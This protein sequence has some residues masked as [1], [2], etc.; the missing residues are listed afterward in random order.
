M[1]E[2]K[3]FSFRSLMN[4]QIFTLIVVLIIVLA[5]FTGLKPSFFKLSNIRN[6]FLAAAVTGLFVISETMLIIS[7]NLDLSAGHTGAMAGV[8]VAL[9]IKGD[10]AWP[11]VLLI[12]LLIGALAGVINATLVNVFKI[13]P[14]IATLA[15]MSVTEGFAYIVNNGKPCAVNNAGYVKLLAGNIAGIPN[16]I[17]IMLIFFVVYGV[18]LSRTPFG[19]SVYMIGG[20]ANAAR[21]AGLKPKKISTI[22]YI[23]SGVLA[24]LGGCMLAG[25]MHT[26]VPT[27]VAGTE[28]TA[29][30]AAVLG[31]VAFSGG[32]GSLLGGFI[33]LLIIQF[34]NNGL[35]VVNVSSFWQIVAQGTLLIV[36][37][38]LDYFRSR[39]EARKHMQVSMDKKRALAD[40]A[41]NK[42]QA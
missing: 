36:A 26:G 35:T 5:T 11:L 31:G 39:S 34:F 27:A 3:N 24:A 10:M 25:R 20:N 23:N 28:F 19:R 40:A 33:G 41:K 1:E 30:T 13:Q 2:R 18:L 16:G 22:L 17:V 15:M 21:L 38:I 42:E 32:A 29:I 9:L 12:T 4:S 37:L 8:V 6:V 14:F 7:G